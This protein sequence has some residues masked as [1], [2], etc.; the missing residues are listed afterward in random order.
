MRKKDEVREARKQRNRISAKASR[1]RKVAYLEELESVADALKA[2]ITEIEDDNHRLR[3]E[4]LSMMMYAHESSA[5]LPS[6]RDRDDESHLTVAKCNVSR[7]CYQ[8]AFDDAYQ[9]TFGWFVD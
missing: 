4:I 5:L 7:S 6:C 1:N 3:T 2:K 8:D 9:E